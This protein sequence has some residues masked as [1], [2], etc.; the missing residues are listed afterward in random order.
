MGFAAVLVA[1]AAINYF[2]SR[3]L[4]ASLR[5]INEVNAVKQR[6]AI[7]FRGSVHDRAISLRDVVLAQDM[8]EAGIYL[9]EIRVLS[10][11]YADSAGP[12]DDLLARHSDDQAEHA[13]LA[14]IK[15]VEAHTLPLIE[16]VIQLRSSGEQERALHVLTLGFGG[17][18]FSVPFSNLSMADKGSSVDVKLDTTMTSRFEGF[19][20]SVN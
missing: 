6:H 20:R 1:M 3:Y 7:N 10:K 2:E 12:L 17:H 19:T 16:Q 14:D 5:E 18:L 11:K 15:K 9:E 8:N 4:D 13:I